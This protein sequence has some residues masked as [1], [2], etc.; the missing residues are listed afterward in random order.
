M[1]SRRAVV[2]VIAL[3]SALLL[4]AC[5]GGK[6]N[7]DDAYDVDEALSVVDA[8]QTTQA[9]ELELAALVPQ[10][11]I[12][13]IDQNDV[14][15]FLGCGPDRAVQWAGHTMVFLQGEVDTAAIVDYAVAK[16]ASNDPYTA[17]LETAVDGSPSAHVLGPHGSGWLMTPSTD[18]TQIE[19]LSFSPCFRLPDDIHPSDKY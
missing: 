18:L 19:I 8:K 2:A 12:A 5:T 4:S 3:A 1:S 14:G 15:V 17:V 11:A 6:D 9:M 10:D 13:S 16:Y 7:V